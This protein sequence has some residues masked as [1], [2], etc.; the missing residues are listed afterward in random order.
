MPTFNLNN[1]KFTALFNSA[2][3]QV[4][5]ETIFHYFQEG[6]L[7]WAKYSGGEILIGT[8]SGRF[9]TENTLSFRYGHWDDGNIF[10]SGIC[11]STLSRLEDGRIR[12]FEEW[13]WDDESQ[14]GESTLVEIT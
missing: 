11:T 6:E 12:I 4:N 8:L 13:V 14:K 5:Q 2:H 7:I 10:R 1:R 3:G 9:T